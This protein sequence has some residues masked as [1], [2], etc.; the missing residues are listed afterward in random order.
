MPIAFANPMTATTSTTPP[1]NRPAPEINVTPLVDVVLVLL[2]IFMVVTPQ[3][4]AGEQVEL[5][6]IDNPD[7]EA[8][9]KLEPL[10][11][12]VAAS[13][14]VLVDTQEVVTTE[15]LRELL[16]REHQGAPGRRAVLKGDRIQHY[17]KMREVFQTVQTIGFPGVSL[18]V[19]DKPRPKPGDG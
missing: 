6:A 10:V 14:R 19:G 2:I 5:P 9:G 11:V 4:Q 13:G 17:G 1:R 8:K 16:E 7:P 18:V 12:T 3:M 15:Q